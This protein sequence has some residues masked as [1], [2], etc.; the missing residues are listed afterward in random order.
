MEREIEIGNF[1]DTKC[2][3]LVAERIWDKLISEKECCGNKVSK[4]FADDWVVVTT[5][6]LLVEMVT[7]QT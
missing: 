4:I 5:D 6:D 1:W 2:V 3:P 7:G